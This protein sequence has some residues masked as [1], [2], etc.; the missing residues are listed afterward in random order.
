MKKV[1]T[2]L[3]IL[4]VL[5]SAIFAETHKINIEA[6]SV[7]AIPVF[8][9]SIGSV[10]TNTDKSE[11]DTANNTS[12]VKTDVAYTFNFENGGVAEISVKI[13]NA[14]KT[15][16]NYS[17][18]FSDGVFHVKRNNIASVATG[19]ENLHVTPT[20]VATAKSGTGFEALAATNGGKTANIDFNGTRCAANTEIA[21]ATYTYAADDTIDPDTYTATIQLDIT[22][23]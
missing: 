15:K 18:A 21:T 6:T 16:T 9:M 2:I 10:K 13:L 3:A 22:T 7:E 19:T 5:T 1:I 11:F 20:I 12:L 17:L 4:V 23:N 8:E 14:A